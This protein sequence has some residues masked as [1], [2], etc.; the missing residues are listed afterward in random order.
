MVLGFGLLGE[1]T[2]VSSALVLLAQ[3]HGAQAENQMP[4]PSGGPAWL[5]LPLGRGRGEVDVYSPVSSVDGLLD[6]VAVD[7]TRLTGLAGG[8]LKQWQSWNQGYG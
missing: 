2:M 4:G 1:S 7:D 3:C 5:Y 8:S 6:G